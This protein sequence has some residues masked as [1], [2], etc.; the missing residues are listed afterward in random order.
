METGAQAW[1][2]LGKLRPE[3]RQLPCTQPPMLRGTPSP[4]MH[5]APREPNR[6]AKRL[7]NAARCNTYS[8]QEYS[9]GAWA[10]LLLGKEVPLAMVQVSG[11]ASTSPMVWALSSTHPA[12]E[13]HG[14]GRRTWVAPPRARR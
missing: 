11:W 5:C 3:G 13:G 2:A 8:T 1:H 7:R 4:S 12:L 14:D 6:E 10:S 9:Y